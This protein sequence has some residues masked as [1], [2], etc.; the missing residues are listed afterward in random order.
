MS[1]T[2]KAVSIAVAIA[3]TG[4]ATVSPTLQPNV[5]APVQW[6]EA[7][8]QPSAPLPLEWWSAFES[9]ELKHL[10]E[11]REYG[12]PLAVDV[13]EGGPYG[14][15]LAS[16]EGLTKLGAG[17]GVL[18]DIGSHLI[19]EL[20]FVLP[21]RA[22]LTLLSRQTPR[23]WRARL[24]RDVPDYLRRYGVPIRY[25]YVDRDWPL[26]DYQTVFAARPGSAEMPSAGRAFTHELVTAL[27]VRG[28]AVA[29]IT[30][31]TGVA[32]P[33]KDE[34]PYAERF[35]VPAASARQVNLADEL[36]QRALLA[37]GCDQVMLEP[38]LRRH[39]ASWATRDMA[40]AS[41]DHAMWWHRPARADEWLLF[42]QDAPTAQGGRGLTGTWIFAEDGTLVA[43]ASQEG[44][45]RL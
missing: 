30:L 15:Q 40:F 23:L 19:D 11:T 9:A 10:V 34:P 12:A 13:E 21:G 7:P 6:N 44:M 42:V 33:E 27:V 4:C 45:F 17:G 16:L 39:G 22:T 41:L 3:L 25:A 29:A 14:W 24:D 20:L 18:M 8:A 38:L 2:K 1:L 28:V 32:S 5:V 43:S 26:A 35:A 31:H 36:T 37:F